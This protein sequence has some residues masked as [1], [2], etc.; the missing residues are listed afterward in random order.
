MKKK[1]SLRKPQYKIEYHAESLNSD[2]YFQVLKNKRKLACFPTRP[3][4][5]KYEYDHKHTIILRTKKVDSYIQGVIKTGYFP[6]EGKE[7]F[8]IS[9]V[10]GAG[11]R[12]P[13]LDI[14]DF[15]AESEKELLATL[16]TFKR[17]HNLIMERL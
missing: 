8:H 3:E 16:R 6:V 15:K 10:S 17:K 13:M 1:K 11:G 4:A 7:L 2:A 12:V 5:E 9:D 14:T